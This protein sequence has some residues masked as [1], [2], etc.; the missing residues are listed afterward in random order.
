[1]NIAARRGHGPAPAGQAGGPDAGQDGTPAT[2]RAQGR[3]AAPAPRGDTARRATERWL[4]RLLAAGGV[5]FAA[6]TGYLAVSLPERSVSWHY[7]LA[8]VG[9]DVLILAA[10]L[11]TA[12][13]SYRRSPQTAVT[14]GGTAALLVADA[15]FDITT[16]APGRPLA[17]AIVL[18]VVVELPVAILMIRTSRRWVARRPGGEPMERIPGQRRAGPPG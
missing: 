7:N 16:S 14:A 6:W 8:W 10:V 13:L 4:A 12:W 1:V 15:W 2:R 18:A 3:P 11:A 17:V 9:F 5:L